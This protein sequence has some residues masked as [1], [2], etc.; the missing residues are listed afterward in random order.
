[1][2]SLPKSYITAT[3]MAGPTIEDGLGLVGK[4]TTA[5][6]AGAERWLVDVRRPRRSG[7]E[8]SPPMVRAHAT[9]VWG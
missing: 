4:E 8:G 1:M 6:A 9:E 5:G 7:G 3:L 2:A